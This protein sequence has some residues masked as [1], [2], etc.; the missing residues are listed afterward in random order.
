[1]FILQF[2]GPI[3]TL[4]V[5]MN[6]LKMIVVDPPTTHT[7]QDTVITIDCNHPYPSLTVAKVCCLCVT[8]MLFMCHP[9]YQLFALTHASHTHTSWFS[10]SCSVV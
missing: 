2:L 5:M 8:V 3:S 1:M 4:Q 10:C 7:V 6:Q 9:F